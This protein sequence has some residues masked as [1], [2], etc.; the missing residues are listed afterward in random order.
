MLIWIS[1]IFFHLWVVEKSLWAGLLAFKIVSTRS[2]CS[3]NTI[4]FTDIRIPDRSTRELLTF[5]PVC[6]IHKSATLCVLFILSFSTSSHNTHN[7]FAS[8]VYQHNKTPSTT[9]TFYQQTHSTPYIHSK[10]SNHVWR[11]WVYLLRWRDQAVDQHHQELGWRSSGMSSFWHISSAHTPNSHLFSR[12]INANAAILSWALH[13]LVLVNMFRCRLV[14]SS[15]SFSIFALSP[16]RAL[17]CFSY[18]SICILISHPPYRF[19][20]L[21]PCHIIHP[22]CQSNS[23]VFSLL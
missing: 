12:W 21:V 3:C 13:S 22:L 15:S 8:F 23:N 20:A 4:W 9:K 11:N 2:G 10:T 16:S 14:Q 18:S 7:F 19:P 6:S 5:T 17:V 1:T